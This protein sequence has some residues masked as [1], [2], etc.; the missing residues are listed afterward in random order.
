MA[1]ISVKTQAVLAKALVESSLSDEEVGQALR[2]MYIDMAALEKPAT[3]EVDEYWE[4]R[5]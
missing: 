1:I 3:P 4:G 2:E 5:N